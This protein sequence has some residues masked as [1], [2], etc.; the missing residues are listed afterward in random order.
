[1]QDGSQGTFPRACVR[2]LDQ[3]ELTILRAA[4]LLSAQTKPSSALPMSSTVASTAASDGTSTVTTTHVTQV[5][6]QSAFRR[7]ATEP[8]NAGYHPVTTGPTIQAAPGFARSISV[9]GDPT[10][11]TRDTEHLAHQV[12]ADPASMA[13]HDETNSMATDAVVSPAAMRRRAPDPA[14]RTTRPTSMADNDPN[15]A[16]GMSCST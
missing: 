2:Q 11:Q 13:S 12:N 9:T 1:M 5:T 6:T 16:S 4:A 14:S 15:K 3:Q 7:N 8:P 10:S